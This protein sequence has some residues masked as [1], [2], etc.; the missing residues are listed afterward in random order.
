MT[1]SKVESLGREVTDDVGSVTTPEGHDTLLLG[2]TPKAVGDTVVLSVETTTL[3]HLILVLDQELDTL[4]GGS[5]SLGDSS[6]HTT[7]WKDVLESIDVFATSGVVEAYSR[8]RRR[9]PIAVKVS[10]RFLV[11]INP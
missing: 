5:G 2:G 10:N 4:D 11:L 3:E 7:H 8:S 6:G 1:Y 9:I